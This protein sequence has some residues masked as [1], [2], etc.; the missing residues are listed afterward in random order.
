MKENKY[1]ITEINIK[2]GEKNENWH[3]ENFKNPKNNQNVTRQH[4]KLLRKNWGD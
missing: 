2:E 3:R 1:L 4:H